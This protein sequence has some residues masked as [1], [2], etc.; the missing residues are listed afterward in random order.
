M[1]YLVKTPWILKKLYPSCVW[2]IKTDDKK[3]YLTFDDGPQPGITEF[4]LDELKRYKAQATFF[5][6]G[7]NV[8]EF[9]SIYQRILDEGHLVGNHT[10]NH[11][12]G[13]KTSDKEYLENIASASDIIQSRLFRPPY[14]RITRFQL[15]QLSMNRFNL[16]TI[17]W[18]VL[19]GDFD[20]TITSEQCYLN[21]IRN[22]KA[23]SI[24]LFHD[25]QKA[26]L[27]IKELLPKVLHYFTQN[28]FSFEGIKENA[29]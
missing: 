10:M 22:A 29:L 19:S 20:E 24:I 16:K 6:I 3:V 21:V 8:I 2:D 12:N 11:L 5:C 17:M 26:S 14:G 9:P 15:H 25:S 27:K 13:W 18:S 7:K 23:G 4:V 1:F 28:G